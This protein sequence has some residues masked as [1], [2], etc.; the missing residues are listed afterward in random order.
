MLFFAEAAAACLL[1][2]A[3]VAPSVYRD[4]LNWISDYPPAIRQRARELGL[5]PAT[6]EKMPARVL[7]RKL[8][9][10]LMTVV[11]LTLLLVYGNG[12]R[13]FLQ[14]FGLSYGLWLV[15]DWYDALVIDCL[16][17]CHSKRAVIPGTE[18]LVEAYHDYWFHIRMS[19]LGMVIGLPVCLL[20]GAGVALLAP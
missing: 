6:Q 18:D 5:I 11:L 10:S 8:I 16:W 15:V 1:F 3:M 13:S 14:G 7:V 2:T 20:T 19:L 12:A 9:F 4:P 17:F